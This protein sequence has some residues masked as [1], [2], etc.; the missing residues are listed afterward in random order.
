MAKEH[1]FICNAPCG[2]SVPCMIVEGAGIPEDCKRYEEYD[3]DHDED[4][5]IIEGGMAVVEAPTSIIDAEN[6]LVLCVNK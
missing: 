1:M 4:D 6:I 5:P 2:A 3:P